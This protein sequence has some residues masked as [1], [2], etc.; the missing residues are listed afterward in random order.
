MT[1]T[2]ARRLSPGTLAFYGDSVYSLM[3][4][5]M[6]VEKGDR[7]MGKLNEISVGYVRASFQSAAFDRI[8]P[9]LDE[10]EAEILRRGRN[11][12]GLKAPKS[13]DQA[14]YHK[15]TAVEVLFGYLSLAGKE[16][17]LEELFTAITEDIHI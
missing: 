15:A 6:I 3:V 2:E 1:E 11:S 12:T 14:E 7:P 16:E 9:L 4:R 8:L 13:S 10:D 17:R 5:R